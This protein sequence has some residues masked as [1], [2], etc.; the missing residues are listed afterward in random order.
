MQSLGLRLGMVGDGINDA[1]AL[2]QFDVGLAMGGGS[3]IAIESAD[4]TL[5]RDDLSV[6]LVAIK[7]A[8]NTMSN[9][10]QN[11]TAA[12]IYNVS[13][14]PIAAGALYSTNGLLLDP[15]MAGL[16][17]AL[18]SLSVVANAARLKLVA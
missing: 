18:S 10:K 15:G 2:S 9:I 16:A 3:D 7:L 17:M 1:L 14:I 4:V 11:L 6:V 12:F 5:M 13:L 8:K